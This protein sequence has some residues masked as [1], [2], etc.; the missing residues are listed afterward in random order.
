M[1]YLRRLIRKWFPTDAQYQRDMTALKIRQWR[2]LRD[3]ARKTGNYE[4]ADDYKFMAGLT[5]LGTYYKN[6]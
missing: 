3:H 4:L 5:F 1:R 6:P 2:L